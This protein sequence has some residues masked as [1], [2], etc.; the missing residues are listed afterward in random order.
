MNNEKYFFSQSHM[1]ENGNTKVGKVFSHYTTLDVV[2][3]ICQHMEDLNFRTISL[4]QVHRFEQKW[5][6][7][8]GKHLNTNFSKFC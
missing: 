1:V 7:L 2:V 4:V 5:I 3:T 8:E 6:I